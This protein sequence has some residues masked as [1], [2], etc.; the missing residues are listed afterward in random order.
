MHGPGLLAACPAFPKR[1]VGTD[2]QLSRRKLAAKSR[3]RGR[4]L[5]PPGPVQNSRS[6]ASAPDGDVRARR[7][8]EKGHAQDDAAKNALQRKCA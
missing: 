8:T 7:R 1:K 6:S 2:T 3:G 5:C 4:A